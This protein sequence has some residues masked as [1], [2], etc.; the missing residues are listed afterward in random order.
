MSFVK[1][2]SEEKF[3]RSEDVDIHVRRVLLNADGVES[4]QADCIEIREWIKS[5]EVYGH[6]IVIPTREWKELKVAGDRVAR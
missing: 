1:V 4:R 2:L 6:G 5:G 3:P